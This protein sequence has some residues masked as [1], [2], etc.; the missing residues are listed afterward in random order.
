MGDVVYAGRTNDL[1]SGIRLPVGIQFNDLES[2]SYFLGKIRE[3][4]PKIDM[5]EEHTKGGVIYY[6]FYVGDEESENVLIVKDL[7]YNG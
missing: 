4:I 5:L 6:I 7:V 1:F 2:A 3:I